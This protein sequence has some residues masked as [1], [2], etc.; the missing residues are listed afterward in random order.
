MAIIRCEMGHFYDDNR[1]AECPM[2]R[3]MKD[4]AQG[5]VTEGWDGQR[6]VSAFYPA[7]EWQ[8]EQ[9]ISLELYC[10]E[11]EDAE[12]T[13]GIFSKMK[14]N[15]YVAGWL[16][17]VEGPEKGRDY[18]LYHGFN[19]LGRGTDMDIFVGEDPAISREGHCNVV[20]DAKNNQFLLAPVKGNLIYRDGRLVQ[21][22]EQL[23]T[24]DRFTAGNSEFE[25]IAFCREGHTW[26]NE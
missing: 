6:T 16:V 15:D 5:D 1:D 2:C 20:Y 24:G 22:A 23:K 13:I 21:F 25:F 19:R 26:E 7:A 3:Q 14:G 17:C 8:R 12:R 18:R 11:Q 10:R 4:G 9:T